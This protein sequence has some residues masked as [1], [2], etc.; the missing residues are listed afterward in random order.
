MASLPAPPEPSLSRLGQTLRFMKDPY[1][2]L[3]ETRAD[4]GDLFMLRILGMGPWVFLCSSRDLVQLYKLPEEQVIAGE[5][6]K[7]VLGYLFGERASISL[8]GPE[9]S[10]RRRVVMPFFSGRRVL[11]L[12]GLIRQL[13]ED[14]MATWPAGEVFAL[15]SHFNHI[16]LRAAARILFGPLDQVPALGLVPL[17]QQ[18]FDA[19]QPPIVQFKPLQW[20]LGRWTPYGRFVEARQKLFDGIDLEIDSLLEQGK[21]EEPPSDVLSALVA[22]ELYEDESDCR[23]AIAQ[24][25]VAF[26]VGGAETTAKVLSWT[27]LGVLSNPDITAR[28]CQELDVKLGQKPIDSGDLR[29][30]PYL[31]A[32]IQEGMRYQTVGPFAGPRFAKQDIEIGGFAIPAGTSLAQC[33]QEAGRGAFFPNAD[34]FDPENFLNRKFKPQDWVPFGGGS[35]ICTGMGLAQLE[36]AVVVG[37]LFQRLNIELGP[38][39]TAPTKSGVAFQPANGLQVELRGRRHVI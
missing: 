32:V 33:L 31:H 1:G 14:T 7:K 29:Q 34:A 27:V 20:N 9:Y 25:I 10:H 5:I 18:F 17:A 13:T 26:I 15:Q 36:L 6:R 11:P 23:E 38:G 2:F 16:S 22:A 28:L 37:T 8:D 21:T 12:A 19:L 4:L 3:A 39:S 24:E 35:R 30:L